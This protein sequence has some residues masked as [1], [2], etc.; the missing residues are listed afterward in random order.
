MI[1]GKRATY[2]APDVRVDNGRHCEAEAPIP[3]VI[4]AQAD[5][6][7]LVRRSD[8]RYSTPFAAPMTAIR[9]IKSGGRVG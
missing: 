6:W 8:V 4:M 3:V 1:R 5:G 9:A 7:A 2:F